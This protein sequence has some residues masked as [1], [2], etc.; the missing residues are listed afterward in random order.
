MPRGEP[1]PVLVAYDVGENRLRN[2]IF[3]LCLDYGLRNVQ[4]SVFIGTLT[5]N[6]RQELAA[7]IRD[8]AKGKEA[9]AFLLSVSHAELEAAE[10][11]GEPLSIYQ[12]PWP[13]V[14]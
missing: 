11:L 1:T 13:T 8:L 5:T 14:L 7:R 10:T 9:H 2:K 12:T 4:Y 6:R 3:D